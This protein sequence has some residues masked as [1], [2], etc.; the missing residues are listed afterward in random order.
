MVDAA[1]E[2]ETMSGMVGVVITE[3]KMELHSLLR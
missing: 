1:M 2:H 3:L